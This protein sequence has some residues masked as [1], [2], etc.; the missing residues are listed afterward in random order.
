MHTRSANVDV[1]LRGTQGF[2]TRQARK[3]R[4]ETRKTRVKTRQTKQQVAIDSNT[5]DNP[6]RQVL[7]IEGSPLHALAIGATCLAVAAGPVVHVHRL[8]GPGAQPLV[9]ELPTHALAVVGEQLVVAVKRHLLLCS[10][11]GAKLHE[12]ATE[13]VGL[14]VDDWHSGSGCVHVGVHPTTSEMCVADSV[15]PV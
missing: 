12:W 15:L 6:T 10:V 1:T 8:Q 11:T 2:K 3:T 4:V 14:L 5:G 9:L 13:E 7:H